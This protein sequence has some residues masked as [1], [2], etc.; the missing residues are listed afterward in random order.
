M[1][2]ANLDTKKIKGNFND[3]N[4]GELTAFNATDGAEFTLVNPDAETMLVLYNSDTTN[5]EDV[6]LKAPAKAPLGT[7]TG[8]TDR[9]ITIE[10]GNVA[11]VMI[12]SMRY[13]DA[14]THKVKLTGSADVKGLLVEM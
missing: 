14:E 3:I 10:K 11:V 13:M 2:V 8:G 12:E 9:T 6:V 1:A 4:Q 5:D 7:G